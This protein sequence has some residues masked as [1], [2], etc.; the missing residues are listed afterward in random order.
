[1][2]AFAANPKTAQLGSFL[3]NISNA[4]MLTDWANEC[5]LTRGINSA[6]FCQLFL[7]LFPWEPFQAIFPGKSE[8]LLWRFEEIGIDHVHLILSYAKMS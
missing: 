8:Y 4:M 1:M 3:G 2:R 5:T 6:T 7:L